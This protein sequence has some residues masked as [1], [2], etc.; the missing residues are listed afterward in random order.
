MLGFTRH[1]ARRFAERKI[2]ASAIAPGL[3]RTVL[4]DRMPWINREIAKQMTAVLQAG[5]PEDIAEV[6]VL[7]AGPDGAG[8][9]GELV[10]VDGGMAIGA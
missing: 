8:M 7:L 3:I 9:N 6:V 2:V 4:T 10:R 5:E 1:L